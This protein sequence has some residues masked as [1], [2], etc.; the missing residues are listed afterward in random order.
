MLLESEK[1]PVHPAG[2]LFGWPERTSSAPVH[3][4]P[5]KNIFTC[6]NPLKLRSQR[7]AG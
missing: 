6:I 7:Q 3:K 4:C 2:T 1:I 5:F